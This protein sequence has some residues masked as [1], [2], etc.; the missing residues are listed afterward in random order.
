MNGG[1]VCVC[2]CVS[3]CQCVREKG[4]GEGG[5]LTFVVVG[6]AGLYLWDLLP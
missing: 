4:W 6:L 1:S 3:L 5:I 2:V